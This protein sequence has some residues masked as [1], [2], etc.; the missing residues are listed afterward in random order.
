MVHA[1]VGPCYGTTLLW[2]GQETWKGHRKDKMGMGRTPERACATLKNKMDMGRIPE[3]AC[4]TLKNK[5]EL[6]RTPERA[7][8]TLKNKMDLCYAKAIL[9]TDI[10]VDSSKAR[11]NGQTMSPVRNQFELRAAQRGLRPC[12]SN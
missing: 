5:M 8:A 3:R 2:R 9:S 4:A 12:L 1:T 7:C 10:G 6:G 11:I